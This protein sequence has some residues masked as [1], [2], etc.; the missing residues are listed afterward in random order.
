MSM[1]F[2]PIV[3]ER[4]GE[5]ILYAKHR[6]GLDIYIAPKK[7]YASQYAIFGTRYGSI[8]NH[9]LS[10]DG[11]VAVPEGIAHFLE[12]KLFESEDGDAFSRYAKTGAS[13]NAYTSFDR[14]CY[15]FSS[16]AHFRE[17]LEIL[18][19]FV[20]HPYFT[21]Q[22][23][24]KEQGIIGQEI[25]MYEDDPSWR[26]MFNLLG[27]LYHKHPVKID[28]AGTQ[29]SISHIT[30]D[31][32][33]RCYHAFYDLHNMVLCVAG[34]VDPQV[35]AEQAD[36][37][38]IGAPD[39]TAKSLFEAEPDTVVTHR[40]EQKLS[41]SAPLFDIGFK[42]TPVSGKKAAE[43]EAAMSILLDILCGTS[44]PLYRRLY[45]AGLI[46]ADFGTEYF[47]GRSFAAAM[48]SGESREPDKVADA[49]YAEI[50]RVKRVGPD[51]AA[52]SRA[53]K[54]FY[55]KLAGY[56]D[57]VDGVA[58]AIAG[59]HFL[60]EGP[61]DLVD[62]AARVTPEQVQACLSDCFAPEHAA[63]SVILPA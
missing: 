59:L 34:D 14:T 13:A 26:V 53:K 25:R 28:I 42:D 27:A 37:Q 12:H 3:N 49:L 63:L 31:L 46:N 7:D 55:G 33:Y 48:V 9:F 32:L 11:E 36:K 47:D 52:F 54:A 2:S 30:A 23:V 4:L 17:S 18:L 40:T 38:L 21:E 50:D 43:K 29:E 19:D 5:T 51:P 62:A 24:Q 15:L 8:D 10:K 1:E 61:F 44:S 60:G 45:D 39:T 20:Q 35:V 22:T 56:Y 57:R 41:V 58:N 16:T 6:T